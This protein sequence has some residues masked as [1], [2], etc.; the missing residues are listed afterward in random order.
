MKKEAIVD[1]NKLSKWGLIVEINKKVLHPLGL[2]LSY[3]DKGKS[4][5]AIISDDY[6]WEYG[7]D[8]IKKHK[9]LKKKFAKNRKKILGS[10]LKKKKK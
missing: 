5:G 7:K 10:L 4:K 9:K 2:A 6:I 1:F 3:N 8:T